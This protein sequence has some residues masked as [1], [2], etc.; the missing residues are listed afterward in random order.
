MVDRTQKPRLVDCPEPCFVRMK[1]VR[2]GPSVGARIFH[3][4]G[5]LA[6]EINGSPADPDQVWHAGDQIDESIYDLL[7]SDPPADPYRP[8]YVSD[9]G[10]AERIRE[11][12]EA[13]FWWTRPIV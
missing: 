12:E 4:L 5:M 1:L 7:M 2:G 9:A 6:A 8:L 3:R 10:L 13:D 11:A